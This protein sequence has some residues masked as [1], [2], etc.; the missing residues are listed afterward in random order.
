MEK[1]V[2]ANAAASKL[3][4]N[5]YLKIMPAFR[6]FARACLFTRISAPGIFVVA[7]PKPK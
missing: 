2:R 4:L 5:Q 1:I 7:S 6:E 3:M